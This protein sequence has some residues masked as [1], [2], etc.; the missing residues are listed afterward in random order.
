MKQLERLNVRVDQ[1]LATRLKA[2]AQQH[3]TTLSGVIKE[4]MVAYVTLP[5]K[6]R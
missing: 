4:A 6:L 3:Q 2:L 1:N 5:A